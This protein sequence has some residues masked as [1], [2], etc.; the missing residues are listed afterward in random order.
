MGLQAEE[1]VNTQV[2]RSA[3]VWREWREEQ[4]M[5]QSSPCAPVAACSVPRQAG[6][7]ALCWEDCGLDEGVHGIL[8][9]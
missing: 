9:H 1:T 3:L 2:P 6:T 4:E 7:A 8:S 5:G